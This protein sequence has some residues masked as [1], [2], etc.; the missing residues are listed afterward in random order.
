MNLVVSNY[1]ND[2]N[3]LI[4]TTGDY[5]I[6]YGI[7]KIMEYKNN[8]FI[9]SMEVYQKKISISYEELENFVGQKINCI[10]SI[11]GLILHQNLPKDITI[12]QYIVDIH[13]WPEYINSCIEWKNLFLL[14]PYGYCYKIYNYL[15]NTKIYYLPHSSRFSVKFNDNPKRKI[16]ISGR[17]VKNITRYPMRVKMH[18]LSLKNNN[19]EYFKPDHGYRSYKKDLEHITFGLKFLEVLNSYLVCFCDD[20]IEYSPYIICKFFEIMS[21]GSLL[22]ASLRNTKLY[23]DKLGFIENEDYIYV[24]ENNLL[25]KINYVLDENNINEIN[26]IRYNGYIKTIKYHSSEYRAKQ[27]NEIILNTENVIKY[28]DGIGNTEYHLVNNELL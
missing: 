27:L 18:Q 1:Y 26:R 12:Y 2:S 9:I 25:E 4:N 21:S 15:L 28:N 22:L 24:D 16:L 14:L 23:F 7:E 10:I 17:G 8:Y 6:V 20:L 19:L 11:Q 5:N 13:G 3:G